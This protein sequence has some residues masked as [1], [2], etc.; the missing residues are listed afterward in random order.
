MSAWIIDMLQSIGRGA[1]R[2]GLFL[3]GPWWPRKK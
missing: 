1:R 2:V 3:V